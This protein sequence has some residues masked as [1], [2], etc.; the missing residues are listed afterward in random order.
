MVDRVKEVF[1]P[2]PKIGVV[3]I[4]LNEEEYI[5]ASLR[6]VIKHKNVS[7]VA[8]VEG[9]DKL[10]AHAADGHGLSI[11][12]TSQAVIEATRLPQGNKIVYERLGWVNSK[13]ELRNRALAL[14]PQDVTHVLVVDADEVWKSEDLDRLVEAIKENPSKGIFLFGFYHFW[15]QSN[16]VAVGSMWDSKM[17][18]CFRYVDK[19]LH[20]GKHEMPVVDNTGR[21]VKDYGVVTLENVHVYH[22]GYLKKSENVK[23]KLEY[24]KKRDPYLQVVDRWSNWKFGD[25]TQN[26]HGGGTVIE[27]LDPHP[28]EV[29]PI[30]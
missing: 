3:T 21:S 1:I 27:F 18:R 7:R 28:E 16:L 26:T 11:D 10:F 2:E 19:S 20:W 29:Q 22:Y 5:G 4:A 12:K 14:L 15:K 25:E 24:Y 6:S 30:L 13:S 17:F 8:V 23:A 9:A